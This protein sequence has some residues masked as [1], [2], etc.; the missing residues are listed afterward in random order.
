MI[1]CLSSEFKVYHVLCDSPR[2]TVFYFPDVKS[3]TISKIMFNEIY[4]EGYKVKGEKL[5]VFG[6]FRLFRTYFVL[7]PNGGILS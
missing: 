4:R 7:L 3:G 2:P 1:R 6:I 5:N